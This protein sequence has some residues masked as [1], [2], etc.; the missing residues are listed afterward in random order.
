AWRWNLDYVVDPLGNATSYYWGKE[1]NYYTQGLKTGENGK[2]YTRGGYL[3][4]IEY[5]LRE[6]AAHGTPPAARIVFD[7]AER[8]MGKLTDCSAGA[9]TDA[10]AADWPDVPWDRNCKADSKCP[11]QNSPTF[12]TR[13]QLTKITTQ[14]RSGAT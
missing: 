4:R 10:N 11:G 9:L 2:P 13:K 1:T 3:K 7:T 6:G 8:C 14:V 5:G 12:W